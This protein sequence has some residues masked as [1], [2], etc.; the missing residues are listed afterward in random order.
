MVPS[1]EMDVWGHSEDIAQQHT[2]TQHVN[3]CVR[4][5]SGS[6]EVLKMHL[7]PAEDKATA[8]RTVMVAALGK[9]TESGEEVLPSGHAWKNPMPA[10]WL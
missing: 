6:Q 1:W 2:S 4:Q 3:V 5:L 8:R 7:D 10:V 9:D